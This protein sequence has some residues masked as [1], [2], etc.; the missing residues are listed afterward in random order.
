M[1]AGAS[2][3]ES[4]SSGGVTDDTITLG[5]SAGLTGPAAPIVNPIVSGIKIYFEQV[6]ADGGINGRD[7][8][9]NTVDDGYDVAR[10]VSN[11][12]KYLAEKEVFGL[13]GFGT[14]PVGAIAKMTCD[15]GVAMMF[16]AAVPASG[17]CFRTQV[18]PDG[19]LI[20]TATYLADTY[21][22]EVLDRIA[23]YAQNDDYGAAGEKAVK[24]LADKYGSEY[25]KFTV[26]ASATD[27]TSQA[28]QIADYDPTVILSATLNTPNALLLNALD[29]L[30]V[31]IGEGG[32]HFA[33][34]DTIDAKVIELAGAAAEGAVG[35][36]D[37]L[38]VKDTSNEQV[39]AFLDGHDKYDP[40]GDVNSFA[41]LGYALAQGYVAGLEAAG[42]DPTPESWVEAMKGITDLPSTQGALDFSQ[43]DQQGGHTVQITQITD[44]AVKFLASGQPATLD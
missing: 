12:R 16:L 21:G 31:K 38:D 25:T 26:E 39:A 28:S 7:I 29:G 14:A 4:G 36:T 40:E 30:D 18:T 23:L 33:G 15:Q 34:T 19:M 37:V 9:L 22:P 43:A 17:S 24:A 44:G 35:A 2:D 11:V 42:D 8:E 13:I 3:D 1:P 20:A 41:L 5:M 10:A 27:A 6:N 32:V